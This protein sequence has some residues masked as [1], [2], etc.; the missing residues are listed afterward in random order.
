MKVKTLSVMAGLGGS[1]LLG[2]AAQA[3]FT[4]LAVES[5][6]NTFGIFNCNVYACFDDPLD[7]GYAVAGT[8]GNP[9]NIEVTDGTFYQ[10]AF[11]VAPTAPA[12]AFFPSFPSLEFDT[13]VS[14]GTKVAE[15]GVVS[16]SPGFT[17][18]SFGPSSLTGTN[19]GWFVTPVDAL[20]VP[21]ADGKVFLGS[22]STQDGTQI[23]GSLL[24]QWDDANG[25]TSQTVATF[26][27]QVPAPGALALL[28]MA[29]LMGARRRR[30]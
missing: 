18:A 10:N 29:G 6:D 8:P 11:N 20:A 7:R 21:D 13:F 2:S 26:D 15:G 14:I 5:K 19:I 4:G 17:N 12:M 23:V 3:A 22:F 16:L 30:R 28:G 27:H 25:T 1:L 9:L 24:L